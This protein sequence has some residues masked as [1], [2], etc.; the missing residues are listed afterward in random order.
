MP[1]KC[2]FLKDLQLIFK[3]NFVWEPVVYIAFDFIEFS[4]MFV[5]LGYLNDT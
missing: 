5:I 4:K 2:N 3:I 1:G